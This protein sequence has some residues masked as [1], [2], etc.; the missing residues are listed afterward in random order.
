MD[1]TKAR[2]YAIE[3]HASTNHTYDNKHPYSFHLQQV[4]DVA[5]SFLNLIPEA[6]K[7]D[8][9]AACWLHDVIEDCRQTYNDVK[10]KTNEQ[11]ANIVYA[12]SNEKGKSRKERA[13]E[14]YYRG[15]RETKYATFVKIADRIANY[16]YSLNATRS[17]SMA[18]KYEREFEQFA[19][20][21]GLMQY[22]PMMDH[23]REKVEHEMK[24]REEIKLE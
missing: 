5:L 20:E 19:W 22:K 14:K 11:V 24:F 16:E 9:I 6:D 23:L 1:L 12:V 10:A 17:D 4:V 2:E 13:N 15:I 18:R 8:V 7:D 21:M 3:C